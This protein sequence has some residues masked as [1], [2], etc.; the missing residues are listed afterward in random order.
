M[1][2][3]YHGW[4]MDTMEGIWRWTLECRH[5][6]WDMDTMDGIWT[7]RWDLDTGMGYGHHRWDMDR[8]TTSGGDRDTPRP[9]T[10]PFGDDM[11][12][13]LPHPSPALQ[14]RFSTDTPSLSLPSA[15]TPT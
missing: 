3:G 11:A 7:L 1:G 6:R 2:F 14:G 10:G 5:H 12:P 13:P 15:M 4:D 9:G 8:A